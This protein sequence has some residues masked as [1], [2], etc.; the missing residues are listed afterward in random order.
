M[1]DQGEQARV[2]SAAQ[3]LDA[4]RARLIGSIYDVVL[5]P[6][7]FDDFMEDWSAYVDRAARQLGE[8]R[9][10]E[11]QAAVTLDDPLIEVHFRRA[12]ALFERMGRGEAEDGDTT[13]ST[14]VLLRLRR[15]GSV[16][17]LAAQ[18]LDYFGATPSWCSIREALDP[19]S[20]L[21]LDGFLAAFERA[22]ASG[23]FVV[24]SLAEGAQGPDGNLPGGGLV[25][26]TT[27]RDPSGD[28]FVADMRALAIGWG[29][30]L[31]AILAE[32]FRLTPRE[33]DLVRELTLGGDLQTIAGRSGRSMNTLKAQ[34]KSVFAKT[35]TG[36][37]MELMRLVAVLVLHGPGNEGQSDAGQQSPLETRVDLGDGRV[38]PV[39]LFGPED[40]LPV[41]FLH[42]MLEG[43]GVTRRLGPGLAATGIRLIAPV[44][45]NFGPAPADPRIRE[46]PEQV[47]RDVCGVLKALGIERALLMGHMAGAV[48][49]YA[50]AARMGSRALGIVNV[51]G[52]VP[53]RSVEQFAAMTARQ[54]AV[55][56]TARF[57]P[58]F[59]PAILRA[60]IAQIDSADADRFMTSLYT[61]GSPDRAMIED[62][63]VGAAIID[64]YRFTV[65]QGLQAFRTD[66][67]HVT[68]DWSAL[69]A[70]SSCPVLLIH[71]SRDSVIT[72]D[73]V[74]AFAAQSARF[75]L[76]EDPE[77]GQLVFYARP[78]S[79]L[80]RAARFA[81]A[82]LAA[83][84]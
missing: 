2:G 51:A 1:D 46:A 36:S 74:R 59:L 31:P 23:R 38:M 6:E 8:P 39:H 62:R 56:Y 69:V 27:A 34:L 22:P 64:G 48:Y 75:S 55:A 29:P 61:P 65:A 80:G 66:A 13:G 9:V 24:L 53:V 42:G 40:G 63:D 47:A 54:R 43:L 68:R 12:M 33:T 26:V 3:G 7:S 16:Q 79:V 78:E 18:A 19:D 20:A 15:G 73:S 77:Q 11:G 10:T 49:A 70:Q 14:P 21:R 32:S 28:G 60:G 4:D 5:R 81:R 25:S 58:A 72:P 71:G 50:A 84:P 57:A 83:G 44:R 67:W 35:R 52:C 82:Q 41:I 37:Q 45:P 30:A 76:V 17:V